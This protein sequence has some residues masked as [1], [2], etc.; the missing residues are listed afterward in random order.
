MTPTLALALAL[1]AAHAV[2]VSTATAGD[3]ATSTVTCQT[4]FVAR[5][6]PEHGETVGVEV[7][8][9]LQFVGTCGWFGHYEL[10]DALGEVVDDGD[11]QPELYFGFNEALA[12]LDL[13][14]LAADSVYTLEV[15]TEFEIFDTEF[16]T[17]SDV[18]V[19]AAEGP[20]F[21]VEID[22]VVLLQSGRGGPRA[23]DVFAVGFVEAPAGTFV[24]TSRAESFTEQV[25]FAD[26]EE[27]IVSLRTT[28]SEGEP[29]CFYARTRNAYGDVS[30]WTEVCEDVDFSVFDS[31]DDEDGDD[32]EPYKPKRCATSPAP[33]GLGGLALLGLLGLRR[34]R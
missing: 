2:P 4:P 6:A 34:R 21:S 7:K 20:L 31:D 24:E 23:A 30:P 29:A 22:D 12:V 26:G 3:V 15:E 10:R 13:P 17:S 5:M 19:P 18:Q 9:V 11:V 33:A 25:T 28:V 8:P 1:Q 16:S 32:R 27:G 14:T